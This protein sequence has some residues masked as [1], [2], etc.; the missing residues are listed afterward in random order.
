[1]EVLRHEIARVSA[2]VT[3]QV[4]LT[5]SWLALPFE[6]SSSSGELMYHRVSLDKC[7][8]D[9]LSKLLGIALGRHGSVVRLHSMK[10]VIVECSGI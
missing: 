4:A 5:F 1:M 7:C 8:Y 10:Y 6:T 2:L 3:P 9:M